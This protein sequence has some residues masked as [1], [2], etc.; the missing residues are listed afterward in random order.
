MES[1]NIIPHYGGVIIHDCGSSYLAY[2]HVDH[3]LCSSHLLREL[4]FLI[5]A[6]DYVW[7]RRMKRVLQKSCAAVCESP[8]KRLSEEA[9]ACLQ[10]RY[11]AILTRGEKELPTIPPSPAVSGA[12]SPS[13]MRT[14]CWNVC[15]ST[16]PPS[17]CS[18]KF[19]MSLSPI[20]GRS[21][22]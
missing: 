21:M 20:I 10:K 5:E 19:R 9:L 18:L 1:I 2:D 11:R 3:G 6:H 17:A 22:I 12:S 8:E 13:P 7:A 14:I 15:A 4:T 16:N